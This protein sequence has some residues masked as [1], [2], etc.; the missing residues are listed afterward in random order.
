MQL[1]K[2][3]AKTIKPNLVRRKVK[4]QLFDCIVVIF[5][6]LYSGPAHTVSKLTRPL[7][8]KTFLYA[9]VYISLYNNKWEYTCLSSNPKPNENKS[10][11][12]HG[13]SL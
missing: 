8:N 3:Q 1:L 10:F 11:Q 9:L 12:L 6:E 7:I 13:S 5:L 2:V 4:Q